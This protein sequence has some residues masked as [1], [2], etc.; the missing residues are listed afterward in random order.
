MQSDPVGP[1]PG[2]PTARKHKR[3]QAIKTWCAS[4][5]APTPHSLRFLSTCIR[6]PTTERQPVAGQPGSTDCGTLCTMCSSMGAKLPAAHAAGSQAAAK[7]LCQCRSQRAAAHAATTCAQQ[8]RTVN[9]VLR[10]GVEVELQGLQ[11]DGLEL[12]GVAGGQN[13]RDLGGGVGGDVA[14]ER[15]SPLNLNRVPVVVHL[16]AGAKGKRSTVWLEVS[17]SQGG[18]AGRP[19]HVT[20]KSVLSA[21]HLDVAAVGLER[22]ELPRGLD[23]ARA[24]GWG[25]A[26][27]PCSAPCQALKERDARAAAR[28]RAA[29]LTSGAG[30]ALQ[31]DGRLALARQ[32][33]PRLV[34]GVHAVPVVTCTCTGL[35]VGPSEL[36]AVAATQK[37]TAPE[38]ATLSRTAE[39]VVPVRASRLLRLRAVKSA[40]EAPRVLANSALRLVASLG[41]ELKF[42]CHSPRCPWPRP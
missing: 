11:L 2:R 23:A 6:M 19:W 30:A 20:A 15:A 27:R 41:L 42:H 8:Q 5:S 1:I 16:C 22:R 13:V 17:S 21:S 9:H 32:A 12:A 37:H 14:L 33:R 38:T 35:R 26:R 18:I 31:V 4:R 25:V 24:C 28:P 40:G 3:Y 36:R 7:E 34:L 29:A 10:G 39:R